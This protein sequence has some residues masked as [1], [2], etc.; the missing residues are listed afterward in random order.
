[1]NMDLEQIIDEIAHRLQKGRDI[2]F[3]QNNQQLAPI[4]NLL[5]KISFLPKAKIPPANF[6]RV[7][8]QILDRIAVPSDLK[9]AARAG[10]FASL[11]SMLKIASGVLGSLLIIA[12]LSLGTAVAALQS[13]PGQTI[14]PM[15]KIVENIELKITHDPAAKANLQIQFANNRLEELST[16]LAQSQAGEI[17]SAQAQK[18]VAQTVSDLQK[19]TQAALSTSAKAGK[20]QVS[21]LS[22]L[23][24]LSNKQTAVLTPLLSAASISSDGEVKIALE[25]AL[26]TSTQTKEQ[27]IQNIEN[28]GLKVDSQVE[29]T[30]D[31]TV[32]ANGKL[33]ALTSD[34][35]S[36]GTAKFL[37]TKDTKYVNIKQEDLKVGLVVKIE[38]KVQDGKTYATTVTFTPPSTDTN[39]STT[40][41]DTNTQSQTVPPPTG[42][43]VTP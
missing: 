8:N 31:N 23:V 17:P 15:K 38:G 20:P 22:K 34:T 35:A 7:R 42:N 5:A 16:V 37:L 24:D 4:A 41:K 3:W 10:F 40:P 43:T 11:P 14:Y 28:A 6:E 25:Q 18:I 32:S 1:M 39:T 27:A 26:Q 2:S 33:T 21:N 29:I 12:A 36:I 30:T 19:S 13:S 9:P